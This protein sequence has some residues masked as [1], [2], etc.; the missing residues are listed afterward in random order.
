M[1]TAPGYDRLITAVS[2]GANATTLDAAL[3]RN[4]A[5]RSRG[6]TA[7]GSDD[8][9][10]MGCGPYAA[11]DQLDGTAWSTAGSPAARR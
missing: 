10:D 7:S 3:R 9:A 1:L 4:W 5:A 11:I 6:A 8:V 2:V